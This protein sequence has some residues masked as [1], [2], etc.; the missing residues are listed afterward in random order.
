MYTRQPEVREDFCGACVAL[1][2]ALA[3]AGA[4][5][6]SS[7]QKGK[8]FR[9]RKKIMLWTGVSVSV[10]SIL[11]AIWYLKTCKSCSA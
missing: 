1:P 7:K 10:L 6:Y 4:A 5:G 2:M 8:Q 9:Q 11:I 3:G